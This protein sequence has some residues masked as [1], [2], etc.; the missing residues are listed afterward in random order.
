MRSLISLVNDN[1]VDN[2][3]PEIL[4]YIYFC[5]IVNDRLPHN[6]APPV[7][8]LQMPYNFS[9]VLPQHLGHKF[10]HTVNR[11]KVTPSIIIWTN[12]VDFESPM[13]YTC[14]KIQAQ[15]FLCSEGEEFQV[16]YYMWAWQ[17]FCPMAWNHLN[18][19]STS[20]RQKAP[21]EICWKLFKRFQRKR[22]VKILQFYI[23]ITQGKGR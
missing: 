20:F 13:L 2:N 5:S 21:C 7:A 15:S 16:F 6:P 22:R 4:V 10:D 18:T 19:L 9:S 23:Y 1:H 17:P 3:L 12:I 14:T 8:H 11:S